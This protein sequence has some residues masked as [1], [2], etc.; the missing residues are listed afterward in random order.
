MAKPKVDVL[1]KVFASHAIEVWASPKDTD[2]IKLGGGIT[3]IFKSVNGTL[4]ICDPR[5]DTEEIAQEIRDLLSAKV[6]DVFK[7]EG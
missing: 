7:E 5:Y 4:I 2:E 1:V 3:E 6:P